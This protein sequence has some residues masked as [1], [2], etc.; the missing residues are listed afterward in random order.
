ML[1]TQPRIPHVVQHS[2]H[3]RQQYAAR[4]P[5]AHPL[6]VRR[7]LD[8]HVH[9]GFELSEGVRAAEKTCPVFKKLSEKET[10]TTG[11][12]PR[13]RSRRSI[14][15]QRANRIWKRRPLHNARRHTGIEDHEARQLV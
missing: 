9:T 3:K 6:N 8:T 7:R 12:W 10:Y 14:T 15:G 4:Y 1:T 13:A 11:P 5:R 2:T